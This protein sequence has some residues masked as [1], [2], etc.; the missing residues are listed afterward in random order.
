MDRKA[1]LTSGSLTFL[2]TVKKK[3][4]NWKV[5]I[6][7]DRKKTITPSENV[8]IIAAEA[9]PKFP[10]YLKCQNPRKEWIVACC[11]TDEKPHVEILLKIPAG[12]TLACWVEGNAVTLLGWQQPSED[13]SDTSHSTTAD[14]N[15]RPAPGRPA[16]QIQHVREKGKARELT[17]E[18]CQLIWENH[19][20]VTCQA[21]RLSRSE[22]LSLLQSDPRIK[23]IVIPDTNSIPSKKKVPEIPHD[24]LFLLTCVVNFEAASLENVLKRDNVMYVLFL[25]KSVTNGHES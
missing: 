8:Y 13:S 3:E 2:S 22:L 18:Y 7:K 15:P 24:T 9:Q 4:P 12:E 1:P 16:V 6:P 10:V 11:L 19:A 21:K 25:T 20:E 5:T 23:R 14:G 17:M